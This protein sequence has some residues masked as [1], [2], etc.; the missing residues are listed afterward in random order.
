VERRAENYRGR[1][2]KAK[3]N[4]ER[5]AIFDK[6]QVKYTVKKEGRSLTVAFENGKTYTIT[7]DFSGILGSSVSNIGHQLKC[8]SNGK[9]YFHVHYNTSPNDV[10]QELFS[11]NLDGTGITRCSYHQFFTSVSVGDYVWMDNEG[12]VYHC[13]QG[14]PSYLMRVDPA[15]GD[16]RILATIDHTVFEWICNENYALC[17]IIANKYLTGSVLLVELNK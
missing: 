6:T 3:N 8:I 15:T 1:S 13:Y 12:F 2:R 14:K 11:L 10:V 5:I 7:P 16:Q 9:M 4:P 17:E